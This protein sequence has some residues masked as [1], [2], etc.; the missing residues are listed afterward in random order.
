[1][2]YLIQNYRGIAALLVVLF[3]TSGMTKYYFMDESYLTWLFEF[4]H[5]GVEFFFVLSGF[6]IYRIHRV[7]FSTPS[8]VYPYFLN[9]RPIPILILG[10]M[11]R[12]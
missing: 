4:G 10:Y 3:H 7:D 6:I 1:M 9:R 11:T 5:A 12:N 8:R 2:S